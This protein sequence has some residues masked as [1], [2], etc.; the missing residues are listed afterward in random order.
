MLRATNGKVQLISKN[1][2]VIMKFAEVVQT[3]DWKA[4]KHVPVIVAPGSVKAGAQLLWPLT[5]EG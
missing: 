1:E 4:E 3:A 2:D 5:Q